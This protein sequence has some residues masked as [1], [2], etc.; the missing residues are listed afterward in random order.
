MTDRGGEFNFFQGI[1]A[2]IN[3]NLYLHFYRTY[4]H[5]M[6][7]AGTSTGFVSNSTN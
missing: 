6:R 3:K 1:H 2:R 5:Q 7:Q 4:D